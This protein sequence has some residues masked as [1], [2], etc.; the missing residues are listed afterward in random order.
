MADLDS[1]LAA[2]PLLIE[3]EPL[4]SPY[5]EDAQQWVG[6]YSELVSFT[7]R[8]LARQQAQPDS[9]AEPEWLKAG[10]QAQ[11]RSHLDRLLSRLEFWRRRV[12]DLAGLE[13]DL[14]GRTIAYQGRTAPLTRREAQLLN[15]LAE[16][17]GKFFTASQLIQRAWHAPELSEEEL[18]TYVVRLRRCIRALDAPC[19]LVNQARQGYTLRFRDAG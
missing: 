1:M 15:F 2:S 16:H 6:I 8:W 5:A 13:L 9:S 18:R 19:D 11:L 3:G 12:H 10:D 4:D 7:G 14:D 17:P